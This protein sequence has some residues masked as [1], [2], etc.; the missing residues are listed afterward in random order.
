[1]ATHETVHSH[2]S[3]FR[4]SSIHKARASTAV[5]RPMSFSTIFAVE[6]LVV[7]MFKATH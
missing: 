2:G 1:V 3:Q 7:S 6:L 5:I 4:T